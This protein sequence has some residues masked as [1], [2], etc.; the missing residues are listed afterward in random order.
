MIIHGDYTAKPDGDPNV[1]HILFK[2]RWIMRIQ[3]NGEFT[4]P[5]REMFMR[6]IL[7]EMAR[8]YPYL[9]R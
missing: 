1:Y 8:E 9:G 3:V 5:V 2:N 7:E 4:L 6:T